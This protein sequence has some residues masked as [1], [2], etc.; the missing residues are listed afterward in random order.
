MLCPPVVHGGNAGTALREWEALPANGHFADE[1]WQGTLIFP[2]G[3]APAV[4]VA[5]VD[6]R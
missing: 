6:L 1:V 5:P 2:W 3:T 4:T